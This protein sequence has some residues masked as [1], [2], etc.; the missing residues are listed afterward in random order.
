MQ[1][2]R[3]A[4]EHD[5]ICCPEVYFVLFFDR[6]GGGGVVM[7]SGWH[8]VAWGRGCLLIGNSDKPLPE[9]EEGVGRNGGELNHSRPKGLVGLCLRRG[10]GLRNVLGR[11][12]TLGDSL[13]DEGGGDTHGRST[14]GVPLASRIW[15]PYATI[16][17]IQC[18]T[19]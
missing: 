17:Y 8:P 1:S 15:I 6:D 14:I 12:H 18:P 13:S 3:G 19:V 5:P 11:L 4:H 10:P 9:G 16:P 7:V 2:A